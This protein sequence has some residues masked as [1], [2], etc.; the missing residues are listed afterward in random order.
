MWK[1]GTPEKPFNLPRSSIPDFHP[2]QIHP[3]PKPLSLIGSGCP[4][5]IENP[6]SK[7]E[8]P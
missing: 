3:A 2:D 6:E 7:I 1:S 8:H 4:T 5:G